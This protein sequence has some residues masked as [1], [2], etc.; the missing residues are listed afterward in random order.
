MNKRQIEETT[1]RCVSILVC[2]HNNENQQERQAVLNDDVR[3]VATSL[4]KSNS[5]QRNVLE[6]VLGPLALELTTRYGPDLGS[7]LNADF[8]A[9]FESHFALAIPE[10]LKGQGDLVFPMHMSSIDSQ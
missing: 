4:L 6:Q 3:T 1:A 5:R 10:S 9:V 8:L 7:K 2:Y